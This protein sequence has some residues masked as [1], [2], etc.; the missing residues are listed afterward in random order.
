MTELYLNAGFEG[1]ILVVTYAYIQTLQVRL[2][3]V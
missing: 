1:N 3:S 2:R